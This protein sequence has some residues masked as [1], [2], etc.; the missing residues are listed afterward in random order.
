MKKFLRIFLAVNS[1]LFCACK[2]STESAFYKTYSVSEDGIYVK[3]GWLSRDIFATPDELPRRWIFIK[4]PD[5]DDITTIKKIALQNDSV[6]NTNI[7]S[8]ERDEDWTFVMPFNLNSEDIEQFRSSGEI[9][10]FSISEIGDNWEFY[11]NGELVRS[12]VYTNSY[13]QITRHRVMRN[14][15]FPVDTHLLKEGKNYAVFHIIG[16]PNYSKTGIGRINLVSYY[17]WYRS[18][19]QQLT[20]LSVIICLIIAFYHL[21]TFISTREK[22]NLFFVFFLILLNSYFSSELDVFLSVSNSV[23]LDRV[24]SLIL[25]LASCAFFY[26]METL[27]LPKTS[28]R[29]FAY[30]V[31]SVLSSASIFLIPLPLMEYSFNIIKFMPFVFFISELF[32]IFR[33]FRSGNT[34]IYFS[35][36]P[37]ISKIFTALAFG[38]IPFVWVFN[39]NIFVLF[40]L[41]YWAGSVLSL[42]H[43]MQETKQ[44]HG[45]LEQYNKHLEDAVAL[46]TK[47]LQNK[48]NMLEEN[49]MLLEDQTSAALAASRAKSD[50]LAKM[51]HEIRTPMNT[52]LGMLEFM[53]TDNMDDIQKNY[54]VNIKSMANALMHI[55]NDI[56]DFSKIESGKLKLIPV[57]YNLYELYENLTALNKFVAHGKELDFKSS[58]SPE[59]PLVVYGD[60][61]RMRQVIMNIVNNAIKYTRHGNI[62]LDFAYKKDLEDNELLIVSVKDTGIGIKE[63]NLAVLFAEFEQF[64]REENRG[65]M[66]S[67][68][69]LAIARQFVEMMDGRIEVETEYG[70]GSSFRIVVPLI[71]GDSSKVEQKNKS[72]N[73]FVKTKQGE[74][75]YALIV[76]DTPVN[77]MVAKIFLSS[78]GL[79]VETAESGTEALEKTLSKNYDIIFMDQMMPG[80]DGIETTKHIRA[81]GEK[82][83]GSV[84]VI[85]L[86]ANAI[87]GAKEMFI[88]AGMNDFI[89]KPIESK[90]LN[91]VLL[92]FLPSHKI[93]TIFM[94]NNN[95]GAAPNQTAAIE[96]PLM[97]AISKIEGL[98]TQMGR[99]QAGGIE[100]YI[101]VL[102]T[103]CQSFDELARIIREDVQNKD[104]K[105]YG[106]RLHGFKGSLNTIGYAD[107]AQRCRRLEFAGKIA[108]KEHESNNEFNWSAEEAASICVED[109]EP[110]LE[111]ILEFKQK[112]TGAGLFNANKHDKKEK[113]TREELVKK[114]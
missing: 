108:S 86:S 92:S 1:L 17:K 42:Y 63:E 90:K 83:C 9:Q 65:I 52:I 14:L 64:D 16:A 106:I 66:G 103:F 8:R 105:D 55:I 71:R 107:L 10:A 100:S 47:E 99:T 95:M 4:N 27:F 88:E 62:T 67:G 30:M 54:F 19:N 89:A 28:I 68:L 32:F 23:T 2:S 53:R 43:M 38:T 46:R 69:G 56:L 98:D 18:V 85:A 84:P 82:N 78:H 59:L 44:E 93:E 7:F 40:S 12:E 114:T 60:E 79:T 45:E 11:I 29:I 80:M 49:K 37:N 87:A 110:V 6:L 113:I 94:E 77:L 5:E 34:S 76:D 33:S 61:I 74:V 31:I 81:R 75:I 22:S 36:V 20:L 102:K 41:F 3:R 72:E 112:L 96:N 26:F 13:G 51:S 111:S 57:H 25:L 48:T 39:I 21:I 24:Q 58:F 91:D 109:I 15:Y 50:F 97:E 101:E 70:K 104:W 35:S 73:N